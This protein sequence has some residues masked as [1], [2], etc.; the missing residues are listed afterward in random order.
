M[1]YVNL[2]FPGFDF[3]LLQIVLQEAEIFERK[4]LKELFSNQNV[5]KMISMM[6]N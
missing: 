1:S 4:S 5:L 3:V 2:I 6:G